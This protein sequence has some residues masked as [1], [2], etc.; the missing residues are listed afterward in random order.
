MSLQICTWIQIPKASTKSLLQLTGE[1]RKAAEFKVSIQQVLHV[2]ML[3]T[4]KWKLKQ[5]TPLHYHP[6]TNCLG[7]RLT[8][9]G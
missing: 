6:K 2:Y 4:N 5:E 7:I 8:K 1:F 9:E 3:A